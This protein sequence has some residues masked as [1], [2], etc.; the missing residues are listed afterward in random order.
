MGP[1][2]SHR[3]ERAV[4]GGPI[5]VR[6]AP[7]SATTR[8]ARH[9]TRRLY[10][11]SPADPWPR[12]GGGARSDAV[13]ALGVGG[14][15]LVAGPGVEGGGGFVEGGPELVEGAVQAVDGEVAGEEAAVDTEGLEGGFEPGRE[16]SGAHGAG[17]SRET[18]ELAVDVGPEGGEGVD[19]GLPRRSLV[20][21]AGLGPA[22]VLHDDD[23]VVMALQPARRHVELLGAGE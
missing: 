3:P 17:G 4:A 15:E 2:R 5:V 12:L 19:A 14:E 21:G 1:K 18:R 7:R 23:Q 20:V 22:G 16:P 9:R 8:S 10:E 11:P 6:T 13:E